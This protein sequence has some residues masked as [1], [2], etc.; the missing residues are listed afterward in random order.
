ML[1]GLGA[2]AALGVATWLVSL[3]RRDVSI[4][5]SVWPW[6][7]WVPAALTALLWPATASR[8]LLVLVMAGLWA[9]RLSVHITLR[10]RGQP[11]DHRYQAIRQR[12]QPHFE[13]KSLY[14]VFAL[15]A[16]LGWVVALPLMAA[17]MQPAP[18]HALDVIG[19]A[20]FAF[21]FVFEAVADGQLER[22]KADASHR[23][24]V[25]DR[26]LW[27]YSRH[28]NYFGEFC[29]W[30]GLWLLAAA[31]GAWWSILSPLLMTVLLLKVS[32]VTLLEADITK[33][34]PAYGEYIRRTSAFLPR[35]PRP[36]N[37]AGMAP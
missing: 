9:L 27:R 5:D 6:I 2:G 33:R 22:F 35:R 24:Q 37:G 34:R 31:T 23:G 8:G 20:L 12:N 25:M 26:G 3:A 7:I 16:G 1:M 21:G 15:Q 11:E 13:W 19:A 32:G 18:W 36:V 4:V 10:H 17:V 30:W 28:P 14:L 29:V